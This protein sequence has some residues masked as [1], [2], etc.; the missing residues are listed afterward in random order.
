MLNIKTNLLFAA[1]LSLATSASAYAQLYT[2]EFIGPGARPM[3]L[4]VEIVNGDK[5]L[6]TATVSPG[7]T[8]Y[9][10]SQ[11]VLVG[12][13]FRGIFYDPDGKVIERNPLLK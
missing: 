3:P 5:K 10:D 2:S 9:R 1:A 4:T 11:G 8:V 6:G 12:S 7:I 13:S